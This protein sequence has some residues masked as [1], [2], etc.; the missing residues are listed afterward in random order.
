STLLV[1]LSIEFLIWF[2][3]SFIS[4]II[5]VTMQQLFPLL[6]EL[7]EEAAGKQ[8]REPQLQGH[9]LQYMLELDQYRTIR[10]T[11]VRLVKPL[12][13]VA[14]GLCH[15]QTLDLPLTPKQEVYQL[16]RATMVY[17]QQLHLAHYHIS[18]HVEPWA[19]KSPNKDF[20]S[21]EKSSKPSL[22]CKAWTEMD[23]TQHIQETLWNHKSHRVLRLHFIC[24]QQKGSEIPGIQWIGTSPLDTGFVLLYFND[25]HKSG[26]KAELPSGP[27]EFLARESSLLRTVWQAGSIVSRVSDSSQ[28]HYGSAN[29]QSANNQ[30]SLRPFKI[31]APRHHN[32]NYC[33]GSCPWV[34]RYGLNSPNHAII[35]NLISEL[36][37]KNVPWPSCVPYKYIPMSVLLIEETGNILYKEFA[38]MIAQSCT[39]R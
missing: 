25:T 31:I 10:A 5:P 20:P 19:S 22:M 15:R 11:M 36:L 16:F 34:L 38:D 7:I 28:E 30:C 14:M 37:D 1:I 24:Q 33:K 6:R 12:A 3:V 21:G 18:R 27:E 23:T 32:P 2:I 35:Q 17:H 9:A 39:C 29:N 8:Q 13:G 26:Q 4:R